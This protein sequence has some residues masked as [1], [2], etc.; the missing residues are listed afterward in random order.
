MANGCLY[1]IFARG[2]APRQA[3]GDPILADRVTLDYCT[4]GLDER[5]TAIPDF[6]V[7]VTECPL[8]CNPE[9]LERLK[10]FGLTVEEVWDVIET[11]CS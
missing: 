4:A 7:T 10:G 6:A 3:L 1:C 11:S 8:G 9:D 2:A 5:R